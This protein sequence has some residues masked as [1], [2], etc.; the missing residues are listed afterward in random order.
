MPSFD[1]VSEIDQHEVSNAVDQASREVSQRYDFKG[2]N[3][4]FEVKEAVITMS[5]PA[6]FQLKQML[7]ILKL[8]LAK[9]GVD[10]ACMKI[11]EPVTT[12]QTARQLITLR[13]GV[14]T[15][16]GKKIQ[17]L[18]KDSRLKVQAA[19]QDKQVRVTG[20]SRDD[21]QSAIALVREAE[22]DLP[23][24]YINFRD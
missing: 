13:Q 7:E 24:Q 9:R 21:L 6:D 14:D 15:E 4:K 3:A 10:V 1:I 11:D 17:R 2:T 12:G 23:L 19:L 20:K 18:I 22:F 5:A 16:L 8:K